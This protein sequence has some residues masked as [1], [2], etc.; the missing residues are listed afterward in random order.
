ML[1]SFHDTHAYPG[2][3]VTIRGEPDIPA[4]SE[5]VAEFSDGALA[6]ARFEKSGADEIVLHI[7]G[8]VTAR[9]TRIRAK[10]WR[11]RR[12]KHPDLWKVVAKLT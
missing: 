1:I 7:G 10:S 4:A 8:Y 12:A 11:L 9:R 6:A 2:C 3:A 5:G